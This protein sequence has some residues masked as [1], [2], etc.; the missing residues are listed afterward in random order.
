MRVRDDQLDPTQAAPGEAAQE[1]DPERLGF[2]VADGHAE[3]LAPAVGID[4]HGNDNG[5]GD[6]VVVAADLHVVASS[7][8]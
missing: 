4:A 7:Q 5:D 3:H 1:F 2:A 6:D 8:T